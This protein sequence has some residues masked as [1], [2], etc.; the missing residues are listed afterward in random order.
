[1]GINCSLTFYWDVEHLKKTTN[2]EDIQRQSI[3]I[4]ERY[5]G[6]LETAFDLRKGPHEKNRLF[7][8]LSR[9]AG[10]TSVMGRRESER[11][12]CEYQLVFLSSSSLRRTASH[13]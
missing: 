9:V 1:M 4:H 8:S 6:V 10:A 2:A 7:G 13:P 12:F 11:G 3:E 5:F